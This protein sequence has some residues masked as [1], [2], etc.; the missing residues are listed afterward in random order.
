MARGEA[1][2]SREDLPREF[3]RYEVLRSR[4]RVVFGVR[5]EL[6]G[7]DL[8]DDRGG[9]GAR[10]QAEGRGWLGSGEQDLLDAGADPVAAAHDP[11][12]AWRSAAPTVTQDGDRRASGPRQ[13]GPR[14]PWPLFAATLKEFQRLR[15][16]IAANIRS[17]AMEPQTLS[18][19]ELPPAPLLQRLDP[20]DWWNRESWPDKEG[21]PSGVNFTLYLHGFDFV[22]GVSVVMLGAKVI[23][24]CFVSRRQIQ[25]WIVPPDRPATLPVRVRTGMFVS[26]PLPLH[27]QGDVMSEPALKLPAVSRPRPDPFLD[28]I[29]AWHRTQDL[30]EEIGRE[31]VLEAQPALASAWPFRARREQLPP[32]DLLRTWILPRRAR[33]RQD[34]LTDVRGAPCGAV[35]P[36]Q[37]H[38][39]CA[40]RG[41]CPRYFDRR[42]GRAAQYGA[43]WL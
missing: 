19:P 10:A 42:P 1:A 9:A 41:R 23:E 40:D 31:A 34:D 13:P 16:M 39:D 3:K 14:M 26:S 5:L 32:L 21:W 30:V 29:R 18:I 36:A 17:A 38:A 24:P 12:R 15:G 4:E 25:A 35:R 20:T 11:V 33:R 2:A 6:S 37:D 28:A 43:G 8:C 22:Q 27:L 7:G